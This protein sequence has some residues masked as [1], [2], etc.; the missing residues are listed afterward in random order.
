MVHPYLEEILETG[1]ILSQDG[2]E[3]PLDSN[4]SL[5]EGLFLQEILLEIEPKISLEIGLAYGI[6]AMFICE[7]LKRI[8]SIKHIAIDPGPITEK[9]TNN[10]TWSGVGL[11]NLDRCGYKDLLEFH[12]LPSEVALPQLL[13]KGQKVDFVFID[14]WHTF[15]H[16]LLDFFYANKMLNVGGVIAFHDTKLPSINK[17]IRYV[18]KYPAYRLYKK[19]KRPKGTFKTH[20]RGIGRLISYILYLTR[21]ITNNRPTCIAVQKVVEDERPWTWYE[22]F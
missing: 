15:D 7:I 9:G 19:L 14:G 18:S 4:V 3:K 1:T 22:S 11:Q 5:Q 2:S 20:R 12:E 13:K 16:C 8:G 6:S 10:L 21:F 17:A